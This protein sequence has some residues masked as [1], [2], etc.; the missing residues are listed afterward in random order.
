MYI[1]RSKIAGSSGSAS[2]NFLKILHTVL[3]NGYTNLHSHQQRTRVP[4]STS[5]PTL[6][7]S[8]LFLMITSLTGMRYY[9]IVALICI[10]LV[11]MLSIFSR[12]CWPFGCLFLEKC[13]LR[14]SAHFLL[15]LFVFLLLSCISSL[16]ILNINLQSHFFIFA[17]I[18]LVFGVRSTKTLLRPSSRR[19]LPLFSSPNF[20]VTNVT[21]KLF[22]CVW[23]K[24]VV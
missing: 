7:I 13:L 10:S 11:V 17:F 6:V 24:V 4:F 12:V 2:L 19:S 5:F 14:S 16:Y 1:P 3:H 18:S 20:M 21:F 9:L 8:C 22:L 15:R 23:C